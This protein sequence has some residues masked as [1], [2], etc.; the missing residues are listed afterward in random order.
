MR[1]LISTACVIVAT[2][3][4]CHGHFLESEAEAALQAQADLPG[5]LETVMQQHPYGPAGAEARRLLVEQWKS[6][7]LPAPVEPRADLALAAIRASFLEEAPYLL[8]CGTAAIALAVLLLG[9]ILPRQR[10]RGLGL[11]LVIFGGLA[12]HPWF[13]GADYVAR[14]V[15]LLP[16]AV[17]VLAWFPR[18]AIGLLLLA[19]LLLAARRPRVEP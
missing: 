19:G 16:P 11:T 10:F 9:V 17:V 7:A 6:L 18:I 2:A 15:D 13:L 14:I 8:P 12:V 4:F 3:L 1:L 5:G